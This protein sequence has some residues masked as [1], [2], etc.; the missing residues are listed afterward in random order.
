MRVLFLDIDGVL[1]RVGTKERCGH[2]LGVDR[3]LS[4]K[5]LAWLKAVGDVKIVLSSTWRKHPEM[6]QHL[7]DAGIEWIGMTPDLGSR[8]FEIEVWLAS[9]DPIEDWAILDD[10]TCFLPH[11]KPRHVCPNP[12]IGITDDHIN[13]LSAILPVKI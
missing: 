12:D 8:G 7:K 9:N 11:Q 1:N 4:T 10:L 2:F 3:K 13:Q 5:L 6:W